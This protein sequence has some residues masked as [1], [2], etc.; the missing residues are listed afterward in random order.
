MAFSGSSFF[1]GV[2]TAFGAIALGFAGGAM[3]TTSAVQPPNRLERL[4]AGTTVGS[5]SQPTPPQVTSSSTEQP[6]TANPPAQPTPTPIV[7]AAPVPPE[8]SQPAP[9]SQPVRMIATVRTETNKDNKTDAA[10]PA[11]PQPQPAIAARNSAPPATAGNEVTKSDDAAT[12]RSDRAISQNNRPQDSNRDA[13]RKRTDDRKYPDDRRFS[14]RR[15]QQD[16]DERRLDEAT[17]AVRQM[18]RDATV[19]QVVDQ[20]PPSRFG[21]RSRHI[22]VYADDDGPQRVI[23]EPPPRPFFGLF[24]N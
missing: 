18:P 20:D 7:A 4:N 12:T 10:T 1:V 13:S 8:N 19:G 3:I 23:N 2:G 22:E 15:R 6:S 11:Q 17:N 16:Q 24:G 21:E 9:P 5:N 14:D